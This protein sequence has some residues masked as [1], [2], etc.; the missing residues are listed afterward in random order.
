MFLYKSEETPWGKANLLPSL[1]HELFFQFLAFSPSYIAVH[2]AKTSKKKIEEKRLIS[3]GLQ[4]VIS[5]YEKLGNIYDVVFDEWWVKTGQYYFVGKNESSKVMITLDMTLDKKA[6]LKELESLIDDYHQTLR[7][8]NEKISFLKNKIQVRNLVF[9]RQLV[10][11]K[12][13]HIKN[14]NDLPDWRLGV[15]A[16]EYWPLSKH[17]EVFY[18]RYPEIH[19]S[20]KKLDKNNLSE[21]IQFQLLVDG[22]YFH[23]F[24][25][26]SNNKCDFIPHVCIEGGDNK[27]CSI[28]AASILAK[29]ARDEYIDDL[30][31]KNPDLSEKYGIDSNKGYGSK[32]HIDGIKLHGI[33]KWHR[34]TFG[35]CKSFV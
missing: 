33:S 7:T 25:N 6:L 24:K 26:I 35:I 9:L 20:I 32:K 28:A 23:P 3:M 18:S 8:T 17:A 29:V 21:K 2:L 14:K 22:N 12:T 5:L 34:K 31:N 4:P 27:Y 30:V 13:T 16:S 1:E 11:L 15:D 19:I 10:N